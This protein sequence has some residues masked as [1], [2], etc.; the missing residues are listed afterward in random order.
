MRKIPIET[1]E[2]YHVFNRGVDKRQIFFDKRDIERFLL[3]IKSFNSVKTIGSIHESRYG[4]PRLGDLVSKNEKLIEIVSYCIL[5]NHFHFILK[6]VSEKG[7]EKFMHRLSLGYSMFFNKKYKRTGSLFQGTYKAHH[8]ASN[9]YLLHLS[10]Y[11]NLNG[12]VHKKWG[13]DLSFVRS[14]WKEFMGG[15]SEDISEKSI[16]L[17]QFSSTDEYRQFATET[18]NNVRDRRGLDE[19]VSL[20]ENLET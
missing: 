1:G 14:S 15:T 4:K 17:S 10:A 5:P 6:Q 13:G 12:F 9:E 3:S 19:I 18:L 7:I 11:V 2:H 16:I 20:D 8:V